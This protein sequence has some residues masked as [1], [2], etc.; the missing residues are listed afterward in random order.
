MNKTGVDNHYPAESSSG[1]YACPDCFQWVSSG[2]GHLCNVS[3][4]KNYGY[5]CAKCGQPVHGDKLKEH[6]CS[7]EL[8]YSAIPGYVS[9]ESIR[10][11]LEQ[12]LAKLNDIETAIIMES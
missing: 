6:V 2:M 12:I 5:T 11:L 7:D 8:Y 1:G 3:G 10:D 4:A 9:Y